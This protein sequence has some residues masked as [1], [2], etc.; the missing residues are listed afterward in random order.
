MKRS[1]GAAAAGAVGALAFPEPSWWWLAPLFLVPIFVAC[2]TAGTAREAALHGWVAGTAF[3]IATHHWSIPS[4]SVFV[5]PLG[6]FLGALWAP[7]GAVV[8]ATL[9]PPLTGRRLATA[10][11]V[12]PCAWVAVELVRSWDKLGGP[13]A[14]L[15]ASQ[16]NNRPMLTLASLGGVWLVSLV[17]VG[18]AVAVTVLVGPR[19]N[20]GQPPRLLATAIGV[21]L[22]AA[23]LSYASLGP[24]PAAEA[25]VRVGGVQ[26]GVIDDPDARF[27]AGEA[28]TWTLTDDEVDLVVWAE[29]S[30]GFDP[31]DRPEFLNR[32]ADLAVATSAVVLVNVDRRPGPGGVYKTSLLV[33]ADGD[34]GRYDKTRLVPF[35]EYIPLRRLLGWI[36]ALTTA[37]DVDRQR[38]DRLVLLTAPTD[39]GPDG[40]VRLGPLICFESAF[41]DLTRNHVAAGADLIVLQTATTT[42]EGTW[43]QAQHA[44][45]AAVRAVETGRPVVHAALSGVS[46]AFDAEGRRLA[47]FEGDGAY[48]VEVPLVAPG[49]TPY[50]R[51]GNWVPYGSV[52]VLFVAAAAATVRRQRAAR[53][54]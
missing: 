24:T 8:W 52:V 11:V 43:A 9:R 29:S 17:I 40:R 18:V 10:G 1:A 46:A 7:V 48:L 51:F 19:A 22:V 4:V 30:I 21:A 37:A 49:V 42:V 45:L 27:A 47:W 15:G 12:V 25:T 50:I 6:L 33:G 16:W 41:P 2:R 3:F 26:P 23:S 44:S 38:G 34:I 20:D 54:A 14:L 32:V 13:W 36:T 5:V 53:H 31:E 39:R 28:A 35:G